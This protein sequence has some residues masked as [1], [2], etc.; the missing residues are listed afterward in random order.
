M[1]EIIIGATQGSNKYEHRGDI[2]NDDFN[3]FM[4]NGYTPPNSKFPDWVANGYC[5]YPYLTNPPCVGPTTGGGNNSYNAARSYHPG[6]A[7][8]LMADGSVRFA[9]NSINV[10]IWRALASTRGGEVISADAY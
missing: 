5:Q 10:T 6:G 2:Y 9:K 4:F 7:N 8:A 3:C 1:A